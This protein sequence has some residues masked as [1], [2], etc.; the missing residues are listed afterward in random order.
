MLLPVAIIFVVLFIVGAA[1]IIFRKGGGKIE[2][3][4]NREISGNEK[5]IIKTRS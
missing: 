3:R 2:K 4:K 1:F 5:K